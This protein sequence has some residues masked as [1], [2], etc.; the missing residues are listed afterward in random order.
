MTCAHADRGPFLLSVQRLSIVHARWTP[1]DVPSRAASWCRQRA[2]T[3]C[4]A[5]TP[6]PMGWRSSDLLTSAWPS[7]DDCRRDDDGRASR[8]LP[9]VPSSYP[10]PTGHHARRQRRRPERRPLVCGLR[11]Q[12]GGCRQHPEP[13]S[14]DEGSSISHAHTAVAAHREGQEAGDDHPSQHQRRR[15]RAGMSARRRVRP[16]GSGIA[17]SVMWVVHLCAVVHGRARP[18]MFRNR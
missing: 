4:S 12:G 5:S 14:R 11:R 16:R 9:H 6:H 17:E 15:R 1:P 2:G 18:G 13:C 3:P 7:L 8:Q 10:P